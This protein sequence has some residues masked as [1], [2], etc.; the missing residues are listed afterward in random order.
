MRLPWQHELAEREGLD[1]EV[2]PPGVEGGVHLEGKAGF[3]V[4]AAE[5]VCVDELVDVLDDFEVDRSISCCAR[6][7]PLALHQARTHLVSAADPPDE[8]EQPQGA[9]RPVI[10]VLVA[11]REVAQ[12]EKQIEEAVDRVKK[13]VDRLPESRIDRRIGKHAAEARDKV[14]A[15]EVVALT[16]LHKDEIELVHDLGLDLG[17]GKGMVSWRERGSERGQSGRTSSKLP[18]DAHCDMIIVCGRQLSTRA[19]SGSTKASSERPHARRGCRQRRYAG[20][21]DG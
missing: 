2:G 9:D 3:G 19:Q 12:A 10:L 4:V 8:V 1:K 18:C 21:R 5:D 13:V 14:D 7:L 15:G 16:A 20:V 17:G 11:V 6:V